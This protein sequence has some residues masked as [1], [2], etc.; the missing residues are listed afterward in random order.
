MLTVLLDELSGYCINVNKEI[1]LR[2]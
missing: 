2:G 1:T